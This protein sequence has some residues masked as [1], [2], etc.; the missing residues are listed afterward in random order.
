MDPITMQDHLRHARYVLRNAFGEPHL[1]MT[2]AANVLDRV[3]D[4]LEAATPTEGMT[5]DDMCDLAE[6]DTLA[7]RMKGTP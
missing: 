4:A 5:D 1:R 7:R 2:L 6:L 3:I